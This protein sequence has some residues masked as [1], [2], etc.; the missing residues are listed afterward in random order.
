MKKLTLMMILSGC[1]AAGSALAQSANGVYAS[2]PYAGSQVQAQIRLNLDKDTRKVHFIRDNTDPYVITKPYL[3]KYADPME[4]RANLRNMIKCKQISEDD[5]NVDIIKYN[6]GTSILLVSGEDNRFDAQP[7]AMTMDQIIA[8]LDKPN[9]S[10]STGSARYLY[11][12]MYR[13][14]TE[15]KTE[16][17]NVGMA[18]SGDP[19]ELQAGKD[20]IALDSGLN[21]MFFYTPVS[22]KKNIT[23]ML[24][25]YDNPIP[26]VTVSYTVYEIYA[27]NDA[28]I[29]DDYQS[30]KNNDGLDF[31]SVGGRY[32]Q[33][34]SSTYNGGVLP[35]SGSN[36]TQ[37][38]NFNPKWSSRYLDFLVSE[39]KAQIMSTGEVVVKNNTAATVTKN[40]GLFYDQYTPI[41][42]KALTQTF[43]VANKSITTTKSNLAADY[44]FTAKDTS[45][46]AITVTGG[47]FTGS[48]GVEKIQANGTNN[49]AYNLSIIGDTFVKNG[50]DRGRQIECATFKLYKKTL[51]GYTGDD[52]S[53]PWYTWNEVTLTSDMVIEKGNKIDTT[54]SNAFGFTMTVTPKVFNK[55]TILNV[56]ATHSNL[57]GWKS[58]GTPRI[59]RNSQI[60]TE[61]IVSNGGTRF[62]LGGLE[63]R[64]VVRSVSGVPW[65][66]E[67]PGLGW[68]F[69]TESESTKRSQLVIVAE[70]RI[71]EF[72]EPLRAD[73]AAR[74]KELDADLKGSG[75]KLEWGFDQYGIDGNKNAPMTQPAG[76][77]A[78][79]N[80]IKDHQPGPFD[81]HRTGTVPAKIDPGYPVP[82]S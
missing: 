67:V 65:L 22:S 10:A 21:A 43:A 53:D 47:T 2:T 77:K 34:W 50:V 57:M 36:K 73:V 1:A 3:L 8:T 6:D 58:D 15:L 26:Q 12:P 74:I 20:F 55:A 61:V 30:W 46:N 72:D 38:F 52:P 54:A 33:N 63:K 11:F 68:L 62:V 27:E 23:A 49:T 75:K 24:K 19:Y 32:R 29:G 76:A 69:S 41:T 59:D 48:L 42:A 9:M 80:F 70:C 28:R 31:L 45:A 4:L 7:N 16:I 81:G 17:Y 71:S 35:Q 37:Y 56:A 82:R 5:T 44:Y 39:G 79:P 66:R 64:E 40:T 78:D 60:S 51:G 18:H 14:A 25:F 13:S